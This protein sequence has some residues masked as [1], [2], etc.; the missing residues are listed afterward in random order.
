MAATTHAENTTNFLETTMDLTNL[1]ENQLNKK[2]CAMAL[3][4]QNASNISGVAHSMAEVC[5]ALVQCGY[6]TRAVA[7][8]PAIALFANKIADMTGQTVEWPSRLEA[9]CKELC[10]D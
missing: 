4:V 1:T 9:R 2:L 5:S 3:Q 10:A 7:E 6:S 8:H